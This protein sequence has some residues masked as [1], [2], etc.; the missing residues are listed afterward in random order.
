M[1]GVSKVDTGKGKVRSFKIGS[2]KVK[3]RSQNKV[4]LG[5]Q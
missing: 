4:K 1:L 3:I 2:G 5:P